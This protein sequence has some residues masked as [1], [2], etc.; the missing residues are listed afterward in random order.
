MLSLQTIIDTTLLCEKCDRRKGCLQ[1]LPGHGQPGCSLVVV[2][3]HP[4][5]DE[6][7]LRRP[8]QDR[9]GLI[10]RKLMLL[11]GIDANSAWLTYAIKCAGN[12]DI[13][14]Q[15]TEA[16]KEWLW[17]ELQLTQPRVIVTLGI[18][19]ASLLLKKKV[20]LK[21]TAGK[22]VSLGYLKDCVLAPWYSVSRLGLQGKSGDTKTVSF[23]KRVK[24]QLLC[25]N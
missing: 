5:S 17:K 22:F 4:G 11:G 23:F 6:D 9:N 13:K 2:G 12:D 8:F 10:L 7:V 15:H 3:E 16:C 21:D 20:T 24:E 18:Q 25:S 14:S 1:P 19:P